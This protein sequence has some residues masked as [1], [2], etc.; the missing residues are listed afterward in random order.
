MLLR[1]ALAS[2][3]LLAV[4]AQ[5]QIKTEACDEAG[6]GVIQSVTV[7]PCTTE[8]CQLKKGAVASFGFKYT[9]DQDSEF[10]RLQGTASG[11]FGIKIPIPGLQ[12][13]FCKVV[14]CPVQKD[15]VYEGSFDMR[16]GRVPLTKTTVEMKVLGASGLS[17][18][19][20]FPVKLI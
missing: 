13:D 5:R 1:I 11:P 19:F 17:A 7:T 14:D 8:P 16:I 9:C 2:A 3:L 18:C 20:K 6:K 15:K 12:N 10:V 4:T